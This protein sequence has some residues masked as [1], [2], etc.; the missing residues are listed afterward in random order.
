MKKKLMN[1][2]IDLQGRN[3]ALPY[4]FLDV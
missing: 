3:I 2:D 1:L 4:F